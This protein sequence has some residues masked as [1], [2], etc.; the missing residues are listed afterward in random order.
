MNNAELCSLL[1]DTI[2]VIHFARSPGLVVVGVQSKIPMVRRQ[3][4]EKRRPVPM[5]VTTLDLRN[6]CESRHSVYTLGKVFMET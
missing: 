6:S 3:T 4:Q 5:K 1:A 2:L